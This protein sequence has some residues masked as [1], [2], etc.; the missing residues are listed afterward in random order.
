M[1]NDDNPLPFLDVPYSERIPDFGMPKQQHVDNSK[2]WDD[3]VA[4]PRN[5]TRNAVADYQALT[6]FSK[7]AEEIISSLE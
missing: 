5:W 3:Y 4:N 2:L 1:I 6:R 7:R